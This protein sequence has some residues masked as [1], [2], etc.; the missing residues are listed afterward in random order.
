M[1]FD[2]YTLSNLFEKSLIRLTADFES[3]MEPRSV[4]SGL[5][6]SL[7]T[8]ISPQEPSAYNFQLK[9]GDDGIYKFTTS[10]L[11]YRDSRLTII[12][13]LKWIERHGETGKSNSLLIDL[14]FL[15]EQK[16]PFKGTLFS[17]STKIDNID[18][19]KYILE[20]DEDRVY[21]S[22][23][24]RKNAFN[25]QSI[26]RIE[27]TQKF[28]PREKEF[29]DPRFY[30]IPSTSSCGINFETLNQGFLRMQYIGGLDYQK[31]VEDILSILNQFC[32]TAWECTINKTLSKENITKFEKI[33]SVQKKIR[34]AFYDYQIFKRNFPK[35]KF[36]VDLVSNEVVLDSYYSSLKER[37]F[38][39]FSNIEFDGSMEFNYDTTLSVFQ[40]K[41]A[42]IQC[43]K[44][45]GIEII[46]CE[47]V[48][49]TFDK[50]DFYDCSIKDATLYQC[51]LFLHTETNQCVI[52][53]SYANRTTILK[54][55]DFNG[56]NGVL[57]SKMIGGIFRNG[58]LGVFADISNNTTVIQYQRL[59][60]GYMVAGDQILIPTKKFNNL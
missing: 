35:V 48:K 32:I 2:S 37:I 41:D 33:V 43:K 10:F 59:K 23:P 8:K 1:N 36:S 18:R 56:M 21:S 54:D 50:C 6:K 5:S 44:I 25:A 16:G 3:S 31:K 7:K 17:T 9:R 57:N 13:L 53:D 30:Q 45:S 38:D 58:K 46:K 39:I 26:K 40:I 22:F 19:L 11:T 55:C 29:V 34:E 14:K 52:F 28:I 60:T 51:N 15:D 27:A 4:V 42:K 47:I 49:G 24:S 12:S 20:F